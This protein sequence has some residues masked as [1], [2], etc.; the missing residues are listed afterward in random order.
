MP[1]YSRGAAIPGTLVDGMP[2]D[3]TA[4][5]IGTILHDA[6]LRLEPRTQVMD[7]YI[8]DHVEKLTAN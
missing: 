1:P 5:S 3:V 7:I 6:G 4:P 8:V 2:V